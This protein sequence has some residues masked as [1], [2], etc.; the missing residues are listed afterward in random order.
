MPLFIHQTFTAKF[1]NW[2]YLKCVMKNGDGWGRGRGEDSG[3]ELKNRNE[4]AVITVL[5]NE[6]VSHFVSDWKDTFCQFSETHRSALLVCI[7]HFRWKLKLLMKV[8]RS[9]AFT[10]HDNADDTGNSSSFRRRKKKPVI[11]W[12]VQ[13]QQQRC[14]SPIPKSTALRLT[15]PFGL[16]CIIS[17]TVVCANLAKNSFSIFIGVRQLN[18]LSPTWCAISH[19]ARPI[20]HFE[21]NLQLFF[22]NYQNGE[23]RFSS[24]L[25][26]GHQPP[27]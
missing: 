9:Y 23:K 22:F 8:A 20:C 3:L 25:F 4:R 2:V 21:F 24:L 10:I 19:L 16:P 5:R 27:T 26:G 14:A 6:K 1:W 7:L 18:C 13:E 12:S 11:L 17:V 15:F